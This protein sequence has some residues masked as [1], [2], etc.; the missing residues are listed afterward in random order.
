MLELDDL[1]GP[2]QPKP[3]CGPAI[4]SNASLMKEILSLSKR[5]KITVTSSIK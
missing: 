3:L 2:F 1:G 4:L 5:N